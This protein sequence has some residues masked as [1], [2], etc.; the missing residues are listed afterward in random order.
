MAKERIGRIKKVILLHIKHLE[1]K[2]KELENQEGI[3]SPKQQHLGEMLENS[4]DI[5]RKVL[6]K[7][8]ASKLAHSPYNKPVPN[9]ISSTVSRGLKNLSEQGIIELTHDLY[10]EARLTRKGRKWLKEYSYKK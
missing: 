5:P 4:K 2:K 7:A 3:V 9:K 8:A 10:K 1:N 6:L